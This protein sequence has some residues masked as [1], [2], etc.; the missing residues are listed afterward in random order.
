MKTETLGQY[1][2]RLR[3]ARG[4]TGQA[5]VDATGIGNATLTFY[6]QGRSLPQPPLLEKVIEFLDGDPGYAWSLWLIRAGVQNVQVPEPQDGF[7]R[8]PPLPLPLQEQGA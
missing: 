8:Q 5:V 6:E 7:P 2:R 3:V 1:L 4:L